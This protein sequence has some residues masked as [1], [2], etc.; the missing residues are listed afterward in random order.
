MKNT[1]E[2]EE[3][4]QLICMSCGFCCDGT[5]FKRTPLKPEDN[6]KSLNE[7]VIVKS[8]QVEKTYLYQPCHYLNNRRCNIYHES[9]PQICG[10]FKCKI[11][12]QLFAGELSFK[13]GIEIVNNTLRHLSEL[14]LLLHVSGTE[15]V[16]L[17]DMFEA[18]K[19]AQKIPDQSII[20]T[21][22]AFQLRLDR[23]FRKKGK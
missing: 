18:W 1:D 19:N 13:E 8:Q 6:D 5:I 10:A 22:V 12:E 4:A 7:V 15:R 16:S 9:R 2:I 20:L 23:Y 21:F 11:L 17:Q 14:K 3:A